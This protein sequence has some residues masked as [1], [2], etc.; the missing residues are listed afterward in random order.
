[1]IDT[2]GFGQ[3][4]IAKYGNDKTGECSCV[5]LYRPIERVSPRGE[6]DYILLGHDCSPG[7]VTSISAS[8]VGRSEVVTSINVVRETQDYGT[9][10]GTVHSYWLDLLG[11]FQVRPVPLNNIV[12][13]IPESAS[14]TGQPWRN[15]FH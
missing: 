5:D 1:M 10:R 11:E 9:G 7:I 14:G 13:E 8:A 3:L 12:S 4:A 15:R 6:W 2:G